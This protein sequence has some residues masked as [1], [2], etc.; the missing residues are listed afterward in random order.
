MAVKINFNGPDV[1]VPAGAFS[2]MANVLFSDNN[3]TKLIKLSFG[4]KFKSAV[5]KQT[6]D[7]GQKIQQIQTAL[8]EL[9]QNTARI[10]E[11]TPVWFLAW[12]LDVFEG[13]RTKEAKVIFDNIA[14]SKEFK[15]L[16]NAADKWRQEQKEQAASVAAACA[17]ILPLFFNSSNTGVIDSAKILAKALKD[18]ES[19]VNTQ[20]TAEP[21]GRVTIPSLPAL[22]AQ[23]R[24]TPAAAAPPPAASAQQTQLG[25]V[26]NLLS[27]LKNL[28]ENGTLTEG[29][30]E[31]YQQRFIGEAQALPPFPRNNNTLSSAAAPDDKEK[32]KQTR[33][34][35][36]SAVQDIHNF[37][38]NLVTAVG[39]IQSTTTRIAGTNK[40][41]VEATNPPGRLDEQ[42]LIGAILAGLAALVAWAAKKFV[43]AEGGS[44]WEGPGSRAPRYTTQAI[45]DNLQVLARTTEVAYGPNQNLLLQNNSQLQG[46]LKSIVNSKKTALLA[47]KDSSVGLVSALQ[48]LNQAAPASVQ[49]RL[50][51]NT[52][53]V[54]QAAFSIPAPQNTMPSS[55]E[56]AARGG[57]RPAARIAQQYAQ[58]QKAARAAAAQAPQSLSISPNLSP[59]ESEQAKYLRAS[60][61]NLRKA[62]G[63]LNAE[64]PNFIKVVE[65]WKIA[66]I[67]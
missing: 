56:I 2:A 35:V 3:V 40:Q 25:E 36:A 32:V 66:G 29:D 67:A 47:L 16:E 46:G 65:G 37:G 17:K 12:F 23:N 38:E 52:R 15:A 63:K 49:T 19:L 54:E 1:I 45:N 51:E 4:D 60:V 24:N 57:V 64:L 31:R 55:Q 13:E 62:L 22:P 34:A 10:N 27:S 8:V 6:S 48:A 28:V 41:L 18:T 5:G 14:Q 39:L 21:A 33:A 26:L 50:L 44:Y 43:F 53:Q 30:F 11:N 7:E 59:G 9:R 61:E 42:F 58:Q 20:P